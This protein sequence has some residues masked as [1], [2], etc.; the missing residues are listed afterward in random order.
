VPACLAN[1]DAAAQRVA[2]HLAATAARG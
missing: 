1:A 2:A